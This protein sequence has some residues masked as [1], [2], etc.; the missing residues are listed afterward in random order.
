MRDDGVQKD[1]LSLNE[2]EEKEGVDT[3]AGLAN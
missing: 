2:L 3:F 1:E